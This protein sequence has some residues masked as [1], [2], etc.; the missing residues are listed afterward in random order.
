MYFSQN[1]KHP[2]VVTLFLKQ[3]VY[4]AANV[5]LLL[6]NYS[7][8]LVS[9]EVS[10]QWAGSTLNDEEDV[11]H[12]HQHEDDCEEHHCRNPADNCQTV[13]TFS[14]P[15][16][17]P[18]LRWISIRAVPFLWTRRECIKVH[19][20][21]LSNPLPFAW[22]GCNSIQVGWLWAEWRVGWEEQGAWG[23]PEQW[24][25]PD[26]DWWSAHSWLGVLHPW[27]SWSWAGP[28]SCWSLLPGHWASSPP[29]RFSASTLTCPPGPVQCKHW[30][31]E[32]VIDEQWT[33]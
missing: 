19:H 29:N 8:G 7:A 9:T 15:P 28:P 33:K 6:L 20:V 18:L 30:E 24:S 27:S 1:Y 23:Q 25:S 13:S 21:L 10:D 22:L 31:S 17:L 12:H 14:R 11:E 3:L 5:K 2:C 16:L 4:S 26:E 32:G